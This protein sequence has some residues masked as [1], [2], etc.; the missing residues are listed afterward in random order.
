MFVLY[1]CTIFLILFFSFH[2]WVVGF[3]Q[4][5]ITLT[6]TNSITGEK[7]QVG[8]LEIASLVSALKEQIANK[9]SMPASKQKLVVGTRALANSS[10]LAH[11]N[12][13]DGD[14]VILSAKERGGRR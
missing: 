3:S 8:P 11:Y 7:V 13:K 9:T 10:A 6:V 14:N 1:L 4:N 12:L 2:C 5:P